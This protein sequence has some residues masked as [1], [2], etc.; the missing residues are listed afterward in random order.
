MLDK[1]SVIKRPV[2][3]RD[4]KVLSVG[5]DDKRM[6]ELASKLLA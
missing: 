5:V 4:G 3:E 1:A 6:S 2:I